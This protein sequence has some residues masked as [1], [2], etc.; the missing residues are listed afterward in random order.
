MTGLRLIYG[1]SF[2]TWHL[3]SSAICSIVCK[4]FVYESCWGWL[5]VVS[6][7][8]GTNEC[9]NEWMEDLCIA[10][11]R[12]YSFQMLTYQLLLKLDVR[13]PAVRMHKYL[14]QTSWCG[15]E[16][17]KL[18]RA[19]RHDEAYTVKHIR[20]ANKTWERRCKNWQVSANICFVAINS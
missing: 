8:L 3:L 14:L 2:G 4:L 19:R 9:Y 6:E 11:W 13:S 20:H 5:E 10:Y 12:C 1:L 18:V 17:C 15:R 7:Y 16:K